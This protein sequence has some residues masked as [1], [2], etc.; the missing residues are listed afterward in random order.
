[1]PEHRVAA[2]P[3]PPR[4]PNA[5]ALH[6]GAEQRGKEGHGREHGDRDDDDR[7]DRHR[8]DRVHVDH[9]EAG[10]RH[11]DGGAAEDDGRAGARERAAQGLP[12]R[13]AGPELTPVAADDEQGVVDRDADPDHRRHVR[14]VDRHLGRT[15]EPVDDRPG[16]EDGGEADRERGERGDER[17][18][19]REQDDQ[20]QRK[21]R[22]LAAR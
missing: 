17:P 6:P 5:E 3:G 22:R 11:G 21:A 19:A 13:S 10:Q 4:E 18:E 15:R 14:H 20:D 2:L 1:M 12:G 9:E 7:S 16:E 8:A